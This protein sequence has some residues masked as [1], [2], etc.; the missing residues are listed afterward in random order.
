M[1]PLPFLV[2]LTL[3]LLSATVQGTKPLII[4]DVPPSDL[5]AYDGHALARH[6]LPF[7]IGSLCTASAGKVVRKSSTADSAPASR[8]LRP[9]LSR[10]TAYSSA[11]LRRRP[12][13]RPGLTH[14]PL[15]VGTD[16]T[17]SARSSAGMVQRTGL[18]SG[19]RALRVRAV[20]V[21]GRVEP[22]GGVFGGDWH[23]D[24]SFLAEPP[25][26]SVLG[27]AAPSHGRSCGSR[28]GG[29]ST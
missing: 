25:V 9:G 26:G 13:K 28:R 24:F 21:Q 16:A 14:Q 8:R 19:S 15:L 1:H 2:I 27:P 6:R 23:A 20:D 10:D 3:L 17:G 29:S 18:A 12:P 11:S 7:P 22:A 4:P 5:V